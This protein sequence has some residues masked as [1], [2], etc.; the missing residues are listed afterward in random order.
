METMKKVLLVLIALMNTNL[1]CG[2]ETM[3]ELETVAQVDITRY[4]GTWYEIAK[5][6][7]WFEKD[8]VG[9]TAN[10][11][12]LPN[13]KVQVVNAG[14]MNTFDG[15]RK[16]AKGKAYVADKTTNAKLKVTFFWPFYGDYWILELG[17]EY[18]YAVVGDNSRK[19]LWILARTPQMDEVQ[20]TEIVAR[21]SAKGFDVTKLEKNP[22]KLDTP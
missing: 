12:L 22:Q 1:V 8:L 10:Y 21:I 6:P 2:A 14:Y 16:V 11:T 4:M 18:K 19:Y 17:K 9:V 15:K 3:P 20:Y 7:N 13:G 5:L